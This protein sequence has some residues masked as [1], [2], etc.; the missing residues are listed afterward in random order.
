[1]L[2]IKKAQPFPEE[3]KTVRMICL[4]FWINRSDKQISKL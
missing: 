3:E 2:C 4:G 1:M